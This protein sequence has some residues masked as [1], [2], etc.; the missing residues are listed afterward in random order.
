MHGALNCTV[1]IARRRPANDPSTDH[2]HPL[3]RGWLY[4]GT[5]ENHDIRPWQGE[6]ESRLDMPLAVG[7][8][9]SWATRMIAAEFDILAAA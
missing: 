5:A 2:L 6:L 4:G 7:D 8:S 1:F 9:R 3:L